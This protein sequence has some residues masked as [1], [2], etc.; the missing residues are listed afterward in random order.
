MEIDPKNLD[1]TI[2]NNIILANLPQYLQK[3]IPGGRF[4]GNEY[5]PL[6]PN[7]CDRKPGSFKINCKTGKWCDFA[8]GDRGNNPISLYAYLR[9]TPYMKAALDLVNGLG[10]KI[11][12]PTLIP[13][14]NYK[15]VKLEINES[16]KNTEYALKLW[17]ASFIADNTIVRTYLN[18]RGIMGAIPADVRFLPGHKHNPSGRKYPIMIA[19][20]KHWPSKEVMAVHRTWLLPDGRDKAPVNPKKMMLGRVLG[21]GIQLAEPAKTMVVAEGLETAL[22]VLQETGLPVWAGLSTS[23]MVGLALPALPLGQQIIIACDNDP[24]GLKAADQ[25]AENWTKQGRDVRLAIP[26]SNKDFNDLIT[27]K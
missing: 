13:T 3:W 18:S 11:G 25:A 9:G 19:G 23:G 4:E 6:N 1:F 2:I 7:R 27:G 14:S 17:N 15:T 8:T 12:F 16:N 21:G 10:S 26:P 22:S 24:A 20:I 5:I